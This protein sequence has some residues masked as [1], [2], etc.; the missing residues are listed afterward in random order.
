MVGVLG[1]NPS[2][3]TSYQVAKLLNI[4]HLAAF[5]FIRASALFPKISRKHKVGVQLSLDNCTRLSL[6][7]HQLRQFVCKVNSFFRFWLNFEQINFS[8]FT[9]SS[10][11]S[12]LMRARVNHNYSLSPNESG[13]ERFDCI[14]AINILRRKYPPLPIRAVAGD[15]IHL[16]RRW[17]VTL[18]I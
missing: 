1:P 13:N 10:S 12:S 17:R 6:I 15:S 4:K 11:P 3:D 7:N 14:Q 8:P 2:V 18:I 16:T 5:L 9:K